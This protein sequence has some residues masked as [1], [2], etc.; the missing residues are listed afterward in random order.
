MSYEGRKI[1]NRVWGLAFALAVLSGC[2]GNS[3]E[4]T[5]EMGQMAAEAEQ[6]ANA[7]EAAGQ[8]SPEVAPA[9]TASPSSFGP[10]TTETARLEKAVACS[11]GKVSTDEGMPDLWG[12]I[13]GSAET[14][15]LF[16]NESDADGQVEN[17]KFMWNDWTKDIGYGLHADEA[18][19]EKWA[20]AVAAI[21]APEQAAEVVAAFKGK[22][23]KTISGDKFALAYTYHQGPAIGERMIVITSR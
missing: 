19:A 8:P 17:V 23:D 16:V 7:A 15:K 13:G 3:N 6:A 1:M 12:C 20:S 14:V 4:P 9:A 2:G 5:D 21:Y 11:N 22:A 18:L 10:F